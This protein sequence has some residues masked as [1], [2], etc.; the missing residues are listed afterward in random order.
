M[1]YLLDTNIWIAMSKNV[2]HLY[3]WLSRCP[4]SD[5]VLSSVVLAE[6]EYGIAKS[7][8]REYNRQVFDSIIQSFQIVEFDTL[9]AK[10]YGLIRAD[11]EQRGQII[12][13]NDMMIAAQALSLNLDLITDNEKEFCRVQQLRVMN[14]LRKSP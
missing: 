8:K 1:R 10:Q 2:P 14:W 13:P 11:L 4:A 7:Q 6:I 5:I 3:D 9:A 12:G